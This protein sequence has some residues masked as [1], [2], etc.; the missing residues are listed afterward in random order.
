MTGYDYSR[1]FWDFAFENPEKIKPNHAALYFFSIEHCNRLGWKTK[2]G[3]PSLMTM[4]AIGIKSYN[5]YIQT[6]ND[7]IEW[8]FLELVQKSK[9]QYSSNI[10]ALSS[11]LS[12]NVKA[13]DKA[14]IKHTT[15]HSESTGESIDSINKQR[16][17]EPLTINNDVIVDFDFLK[18]WN[19]YNKKVGDKA[20]ILKKWLALKQSER[21]LIFKTLP[22]YLSTV[23]DKKFQLN[24]ETYLNGKR[25]KDERNQTAT[26]TRP[27]GFTPQLIYR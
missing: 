27:D 26:S 15:K 25:W 11:A 7:L 10:I 2:F 4:E 21:D 19:L 22:A 3:L 14:L 9:N 5:T 12:K 17:I 20:K 1:G 23:T 6:F 16:T 8:G 13:L 18:F 24:P